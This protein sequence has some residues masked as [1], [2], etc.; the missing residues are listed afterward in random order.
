MVVFLSELCSVNY[1]LPSVFSLLECTPFPSIGARIFF[2]LRTSRSRRKV[3][4]RG[5]LRETL[6]GGR[7]GSL[8]TVFPSVF[9]GNSP[10]KFVSVLLISLRPRTGVEAP[11]PFLLCAHRVLAAALFSEAFS[12]IIAL[13]SCSSI[14]ALRVLVNGLAFGVRFE[15]L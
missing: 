4:L 14:R 13:L 10:W 11:L 9:V 7:R 6:A 5:A 1:G 12:G 15:R 2:A 3:C 8:T